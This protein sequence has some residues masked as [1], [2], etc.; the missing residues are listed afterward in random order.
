MAEERQKK[1]SAKTTRAQ[2]MLYLDEFQNNAAFRTNKYNPSDPHVLN[3]SWAQLT[4]QLNSVSGPCK[5]TKDWKKVSFYMNI[6][7]SNCYD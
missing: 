2:F 4:N 6:A 1:R 5:S 7:I 3:N